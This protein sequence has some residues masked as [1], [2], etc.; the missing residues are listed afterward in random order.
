MNGGARVLGRVHDMH[1]R[2]IEREGWGDMN[3]NYYQGETVEVG[4]PLKVM[5]STNEER[6]RSE[7]SV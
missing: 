4:S 2:G 3:L 5:E 6:R 1:H 7:T